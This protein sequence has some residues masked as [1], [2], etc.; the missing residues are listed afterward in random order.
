MITIKLQG[1]LGN[2]LFQLAAIQS[3]AKDSGKQFY[4]D[5]LNSPRTVHSNE[6]YFDSIFKEFKTDFK[7]IKSQ[8]TLVENSNLKEEY[9]VHKVKQYN[10]VALL[11]YFQH[12]KYFEHY[13]HEFIKK[14]S[15]NTIILDKYPDI[16]NKVFIHIRGGDYLKIWQMFVDLRNY[17]KDAINQFKGE[18]FVV[19]TN[20][21][22]Y[23]KQF[24]NDID[25][26]YIDENE[27]DTLYLMSK[28]KGCICANSSFSWWGA[29][30][31]PDRKITMP[32]KWFNASWAYHNYYF[33]GVT[34]VPI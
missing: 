8:I 1:G 24:L 10:S 4:V 34:I 3:F 25:Y 22:N 12:Y 19:F 29:Y 23:S 18:K 27:V 9:W 6:Q 15:F 11:G 14:L 33:K 13:K 20:D 28:C 5:S 17:Y 26:E 32:S 30:L 7:D 31:N 21:K 16:S 2:Q